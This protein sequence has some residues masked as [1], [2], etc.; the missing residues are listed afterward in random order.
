[1]LRI[2]F[3]IVE[4]IGGRKGSCREVLR[5]APDRTM[6]VATA[7]P[8]PARKRIIQLQIPLTFREIEFLNLAANG[9]T[10][11]EISAELDVTERTANFHIKSVMRKLGAANKTHA[12]ALAMRRGII[13]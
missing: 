8:L 7:T 9:M 13:G 11:R 12:V 1:M 5:Y 4:L 10:A 3:V 2:S 6:H